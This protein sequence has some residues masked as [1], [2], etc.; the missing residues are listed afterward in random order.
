M[1]RSHFIEGGKA[2]ICDIWNTDRNLINR[3]LENYAF[4]LVLHRF[5][6]CDF[7]A[8]ALRVCSARQSVELTVCCG[9]DD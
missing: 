7:G 8:R 6:T 9:A 3:Q 1:L 4:Y 2:A 5:F